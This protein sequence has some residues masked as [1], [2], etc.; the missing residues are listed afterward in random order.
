[1][2]C[3]RTHYGDFINFLASVV[4]EI[5]Y[6]CCWPFLVRLRLP[7][8]SAHG[9]SIHICDPD[10]T[11]T[12]PMCMMSK[13]PPNLVYRI[14]GAD[15]ETVAMCEAQIYKTIRPASSRLKQ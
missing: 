1:M 4:F 10:V 6:G 9:D 14:T 11:L 15:T 12:R 8:D 2:F 3:S 7:V 13:Q 5:I